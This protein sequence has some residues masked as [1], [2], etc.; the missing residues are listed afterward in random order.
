LKSGA[1]LSFEVNNYTLPA[2]LKNTHRPT[3]LTN[4]SG[5][6]SLDLRVSAKTLNFAP[7]FN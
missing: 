5:Y 7:D 1:K 4:I 3:K 6:R 2:G